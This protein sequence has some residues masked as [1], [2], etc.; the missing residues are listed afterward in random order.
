M[1][2]AEKIL[3][4]VQALPPAKQAEVL[5]FIEFISSR[6][7]QQEEGEWT[8]FSLSTAMRGLESEPAPYSLSDLK[9]PFP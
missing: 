5:D 1:N 3:C 4:H 2:L 7:A 9:E 6:T 8:E